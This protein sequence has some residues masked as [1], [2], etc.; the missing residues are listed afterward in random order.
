MGLRD[1]L[2][3]DIAEAL[4]SDLADAVDTFTCTRKKLT[5]SNP[6]TGEDTY[7]EINYSGRGVRGNYLEQ[8]NLPID[9]K[10]SDIR[11]LGL[12]NEL[13]ETPLIGDKLIFSD[14]GYSI[15][16]IQQD[17]AKVTWVLQIRKV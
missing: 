1:E 11:F 6:A 8:R 4:N 15:I 13:T 14:G 9:Y 10:S 12:Q 7:T 17:P 3:A 2:Q 5:G 16:S